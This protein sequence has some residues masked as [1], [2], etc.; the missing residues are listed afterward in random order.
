MGRNTKPIPPKIMARILENAGAHRVSKEAAQLL[1]E[2]VEEKAKEICE[3]AIKI[4]R[5]AGRNTV[6]D[7]DI[8]LSVRKN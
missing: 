6:M 2:L 5:H 1:A 3:Q 8:K 4:S 7:G